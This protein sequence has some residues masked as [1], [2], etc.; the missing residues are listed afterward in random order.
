[1]D[2]FELWDLL[3]LT[4]RQVLKEIELNVMRW[5]GC[6]RFGSVKLLRALYGLEVEERYNAVL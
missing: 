1:M 4:P 3:R 5:V 6:F 2:R